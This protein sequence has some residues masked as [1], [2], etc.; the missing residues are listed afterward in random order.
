ME[1]NNNNMQKIHNLNVIY[2]ANT[3]NCNISNIGGNIGIGN[4]YNKKISKKKL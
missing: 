1:S 4:N 3:Y 2:N